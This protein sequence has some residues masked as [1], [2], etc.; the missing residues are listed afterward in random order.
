MTLGRRMVAFLVMECLEGQTLADRLVKG[1]LPLEQVLKI[2]A[3]IAEAL[4]KAHRQG[5]A[6]RDLKPGNIMLTKSGAKLMD[7]GLA[8]PELAVAT[9]TKGL[10]T[11]ST[12]TMNLASLTS[13]ASPL[14]QK[15]SIVGTFQYLAPEVLQGSEADGRSDLFSLGCVLYEMVTGRRAFEG[16][17]QLGVLTAILEKEPE[18]IATTPAAPSMLDRVVRACLAKDPVDRYQAA[19]DV[20]MDLRWMV[21]SEGSEEAKPAREFK[22]SWAI[23]LAA[24]VVVLVGLAALGGFWWSKHG[25]SGKAL[26]AEYRRRT[27]SRSTPPETTAACRCCHPRATRLRLSLIPRT[28]NPCGCRSLES[29]TVQQLEGTQGA[30]HPFWSPDG[31]YVGFFAY[32]KL[33]KIAV[34]GGPVS[35]IADA[36]NPRGGTWNADDVIVFSPDFRDALLKVSAQ[37]GT[38]VPATV[39]D[40]EKHTTHRWPWFLPDGKHFIFLA[41]SHTAGNPEYDGIYFGSVDSTQSHMVVPS[42]SGAQY[43]SGHLLY[44]ANRALVAQPFDPTAGKLSGSPVPLISNVRY[45]S[46]VWRSIFAVSQNGLMV[47]QTG[48]AA[49]AGTRLVW[50]DRSGKQIGDAGP[51]ENGLFDVTLSPDSRRVAFVA[52]NPATDIWVLDL[53]RKTK[54]RITFEETVQ[55]PAWSPDSKTLAF[56][57]NPGQGGG[58]VEIRS[59]AADGSGTEKTLVSTPRSYHYPGWSPEGKYLTYILGMGEKMLSLWAVP[60]AG[61][62][63]PIA[64]V[65]PPS[66]RSNIYGYRISPDGRLVAYISD[67]SGQNELYI[68]TFPEGKGKWKVSSGGASYPRWS[69]NGKEV[70]FNNLNDDFF[71]CPLTFKGSEIEVGTPQRLFHASMPGIG[72]PYD[73]SADGQRFLVNLAEEEGAAPL[74][75]VVNWP[76]ELKK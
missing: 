14:T 73:V 68:T 54:T 61:D 13:A 64:V 38:A 40:K 7:F 48:S 52:G 22:K 47:C 33:N 58:L 27:S 5:I 62:A 12:P 37:G 1:A 53:E 30:I 72:V 43:A 65:Q 42:D 35:V 34:S 6:H 11:P 75:L 57:V 55:Y 4:E 10:L 2:G 51:R 66:Q 63:Q 46:G 20:A 17:S 49:A 71:S 45:D 19:H 3:E 59:R 67:E 29:D 26:H 8:K 24:A 32:R 44:H 31:R 56:A 70:F 60:V 69:G 41:T 21:D 39:L 9:G 36:P 23:L 74:F 18:P 76:A 28:P 16:K 25:E 50:F 15:G